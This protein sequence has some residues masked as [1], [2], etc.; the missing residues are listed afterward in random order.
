MTV[1]EVSTLL[2]VSVRALHHWDETGLVHPSRRSAAGYR[3]YCEADIMRIQQV[4][5]YRQTGMNL[6]DIKMVLDEPETDAMTHLRRQ[7]ELVQGQV[8]HLQQMLKSINMVMEIHQ[9]GA[10]ISV[11]E[12]AEIWGTDWD[13][14]YI[15]EAQARWGDTED[16]AESA[17]R[18]SQMTRTDWEQAHEET[19]A[20]E[21]A[22]AEAMCSGVEP[23]SPEANALARWHRKDLN[24]WFEVSTSK[25]VLIAR[26]YVV[27]ERFARYYDKRAPGLAAWLKDVIDAGARSEGVDPTTAVW[28]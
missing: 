10:R 18:K 11:A 17:R 1:G 2:G 13:P 19:V 4:L 6:A 20:L 7:R 25:Q 14:A 8:S 9:S 22:L 23:G 27:D 15:G 28:E 5:V 21:A 16:W 3:L 12:M 26:D 24:R